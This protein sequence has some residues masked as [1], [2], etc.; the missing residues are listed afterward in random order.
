[1]AV[2]GALAVGGYLMA[3][4]GSTARP[5]A[6]TVGTPG[7]STAASR[8]GPSTSASGPGVSSSRTTGTAQPA[9]GPVPAGFD[10]VSFTAVSADEYWLLGTAPCPNPVC[11]SIVRTTDGGSSFVGLPAPPA[12]VPTGGSQPAGFVTTLRFADQADGYAFGL[13]AG[14]GFWDTHD[15]GGHWSQPGFLSGRQLLGFGT[16]AGDAFALVGSC[17][18]GGCSGLSLERSPVGTDAWTALALPVPD[19]SGPADM[20]VQGPDIWISVTT[21]TSSEYQLLVR[22]TDSGATFTTGPS[23]CYAG[24]GGQIEPSSASV[25]WATCPTG[26]EAQALRSSDGGAHWATL[27]TGAATGGAGLAN[28]AVLAPASATTAVLEPGPTGELLRTTDGGASWSV[29]S[30]APPGDYWFS[31]IGFTD[32]STGSALRVLQV[33]QGGSVNQ[34]WRSSDGGASWAGPVR[35]S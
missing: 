14:G 29:V 13:G 22:S 16:G 6:T 10:P 34:L 3:A 30:S 4:C 33:P 27:Q 19:G 35:F 20:A 9:G 12:P 2:V 24:L 32:P 17:G 26:M 11:T 25:L 8:P 5:G 23:P 28:S 15:G 18:Q 7:P 21:P 1:V 31:W